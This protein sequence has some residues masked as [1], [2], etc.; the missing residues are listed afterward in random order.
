MWLTLGTMWLK[1]RLH[2]GSKAPDSHSFGGH[3]SMIQKQNSNKSYYRLS[4]EIYVEEQNTTYNS[5]E[6]VNS[7]ADPRLRT[8][9]LNTAVNRYAPCFC[10]QSLLSR[11]ISSSP[12]LIL[13]PV[14]VPDQPAQYANT[15]ESALSQLSCDNSFLW[16]FSAKKL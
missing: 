13:F 4:P 16:L 10:L 3:G 12:N 15:Y 8:S 5:T 6:L 11:S 1:S 14:P 2:W 9:V 7:A